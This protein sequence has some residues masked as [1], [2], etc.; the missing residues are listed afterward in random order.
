M[1]VSDGNGCRISPRGTWF[2]R[3]CALVANG[4][5]HLHVKVD[6]LRPPHVGFL[7]DR[8][9]RHLNLHEIFVYIPLFMSE[10]NYVS[11]NIYSFFG[12]YHKRRDRQKWFFFL[13]LKQHDLKPLFWPDL[14]SCHYSKTVQE[15]NAAFVPNDMSPPN[16]PEFRSFETVEHDK[17]RT[18]GVQKR[19]EGQQWNDDEVDTK[20]WENHTGND[21]KFNRRM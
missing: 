16:C 8:I 6:F 20:N 3:P 14:A 19:G 18:S 10:M 5:N 2:Y 21:V 9:I 1:I 15:W 12:V 13:F 11:C 17:A 7:W 4:V